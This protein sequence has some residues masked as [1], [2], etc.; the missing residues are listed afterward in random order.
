MKIYILL[1]LIFLISGCGTNNSTSTAETSPF[2]FE[3][4]NEVAVSKSSIP[5]LAILVNYDNIQIQ[6]SDSVWSNKLFGKNEHQLNHYYMQTSK[7]NFSFEKAKESART[8]DD[9]IVAVL[10]H[11]NHPNTDI[12]TISFNNSVYPDLSAALSAADSVV[13]FS[14][15]DSNADGAITPDEL[16][17]TFIIAGYEDSY[18]GRHVNNGIWA[19][20]NC[21][22]NSLIIPTL[23]SVKLMSC[24]MGGNF[25]L[26]GE[27]H[28]IQNPHDATIGIIAHELGHATFNLPDL[29]NTTN[30]DSGG[31]GFFGLMGGG[32]W[33]VQNKTEYFG[34]TPTH[35][36]AWSKIYNGWITPTI[37]NS[38]STVLY[39]TASLDYNIIKIPINST[40]YYL[41]ENRNNS[42]YDKGLYSLNGH[43][44]GGIAIW[45][46]DETQISTNDL[47]YNTVNANTAQKGIDL[48]EAIYG[49][50]DTGGD[51]DE[52]ALYYQGN[53]NS[54]KTL[55][56]DI[57]PRGSVM[58]L[59]IN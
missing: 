44:N 54:F 24:S 19:H 59:N 37:E 32:T 6:S 47:F 12:N 33:T 13:D 7:N 27:R 51:G 53:V 43:F 46:I 10:L 17:L 4:T 25:A 58:N 55:V 48:V 36:S 14:N 56:S 5:M 15:Y 50:I 23:D 16:I 8:V 21:I 29:Y 45:K 39:E 52:N 40:S 22:Q 49:K 3:T 42:G 35:L 38:T 1:S 28:N 31:I 57:S 9:G 41:L 2:I 18:E 34:N 11:K 30:Q 20:E 26:F